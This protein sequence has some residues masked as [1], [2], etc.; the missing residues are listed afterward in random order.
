M[1]YSIPQKY[2]LDVENLRAF[3]RANLKPHLT[4]WY[5]EGVIP[6]EFFRLMASEGWLGVQW[7]DG[8]AEKTPALREALIQEELAKMSA[9]VAV[10][11]LGHVHPRVAGLFLFGFNSPLD[12]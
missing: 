5:R 4:S 3:L 6:K 12:E 11:V 1:D 9:G 7:T 2:I 8:K 10:S